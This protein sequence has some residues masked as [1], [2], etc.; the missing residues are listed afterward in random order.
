MFFVD[1]KQLL[2]EKARFSGLSWI[3]LSCRCRRASARAGLQH[4]HHAPRGERCRESAHTRVSSRRAC[5]RS[6]DRA[7]APCTIASKLQRLFASRCREIAPTQ[8]R[9]F[10]ALFLDR[11]TLV[12]EMRMKPFSK[13]LIVV[14]S[15][16]L[17][18]A[19][20]AQQGST[21]SNSVGA[22]FAPAPSAS[23]SRRH[24]RRRR[25]L[26]AGPECRS[27]GI[28][29]RQQRRRGSGGAGAGPECRQRPAWVSPVSLCVTEQ[30]GRG[31]HSA[32]W[33]RY[34]FQATTSVFE[35]QKNASG[36]RPQARQAAAISSS[37][38]RVA[39]ANSSA[40]SAT[41]EWSVRSA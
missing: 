2:G 17:P 3:A 41:F 26:D 35:K 13:T 29:G 9:L 38:G 22:N 24:D 14:A 15:L 1:E 28:D 16:V 36:S 33:L 11:P 21:G 37:S 25:Y 30:A 19:A 27:G 20:S 6:R 5:S 40:R 4:V 32:V 7:R 12:M 39:R 31:G 8:S 34:A 18:F 10:S 23:A